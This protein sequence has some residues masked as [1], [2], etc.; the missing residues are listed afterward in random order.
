MVL[1]NSWDIPY[2]ASVLQSTL[3]GVPNPLYIQV[4]ELKQ[5]EVIS[6]RSHSCFFAEKVLAHK[7]SQCST[8]HALIDKR[9]PW[10]DDTCTGISRPRWVVGTQVHCRHKGKGGVKN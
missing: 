8:H 10:T 3:W 4:T 2:L 1:P 6:P 9:F 7:A 5:S